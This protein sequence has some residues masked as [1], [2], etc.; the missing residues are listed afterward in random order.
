MNPDDDRPTLEKLISRMLADEPVVASAQ[1]TAELTGLTAEEA[2]HLNIIERVF[3]G[4]E[5]LRN[6]RTATAPAPHLPGERVGAFALVRPL[7]AGG[8][9]EVWLAERADGQVEQRVAMKFLRVSQTRFAEWFLREQ[10]LLARLEHPGIARF[11]DAGHA[12]DGAPYLAME[13]VDGEPVDAWC[14]ARALG[15]DARL[16]LFLRACES[17]DHAHRHLV[18]HRDVK[19]ANLLV[20]ADG[21]PKLLDFGIGKALGAVSPDTLTLQPALT[22][23]YAAPE[24]FR[25]EPVSTATD[26]FSLGLLL[27]R[28]LAGELPAA[29]ANA[30]VASLALGDATLESLSATARA[31]GAAPVAA[32][33]LTGD[34]DA[35]A[36]KATQTDPRERYGTVAAL[37]DDIERWRRRVPVA[38]RKATRGYRLRRFVA[39]HRAGVAAAAFAIVALAAG[40][41]VALW[42]ADI[43]RREAQRADA[44][45]AR[46]QRTADFVTGILRE[47]DPLERGRGEAR[48]ARDLVDEGVLRARSD[49]ADQ[50]DVRTAMLTVL[51]EA[52]YNLGD[53]AAARTLLDDA[54]SAVA[55]DTLD[56]ARIDGILARIAMKQGRSAAAI[57]LLDNA[58]ARLAAGSLDDRIAAARLETWRGDQLLRQ[59]KG[60]AGVAAM[61]AARASLASLV[62]PDSVAMLDVDTAFALR[63][64][65]MRQDAEAAPFLREL[66]ARIERV[67]GGDSARLIDPLGALA[68]LEKRAGNYDTAQT[69]YA[70][71]IAIA[72]QRLG[73][74][75]ETLA[76]LYSRSA[77]AY[78]DAGDPQRALERLALAEQALPPDANTERAQILAT[79][80]ATLLDVDRNA[81]AEQALRTALELRRAS[82]GDG[83]G[84]T[85]YS[86]SEWGRALRALGR[87]DEA[88]KVQREALERLERIMGSE[89][90]QLTFALRNLS[91][92][93]IAAGEFTQAADA[94]RRAATLA[95]K[96]YP[97]THRVVLQYQVMLGEALVKTGDGKGALEAVAPVLAARDAAGVKDL[98]EAAERVRAAKA[99]R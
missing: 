82:A 81:E 27:Y 70:R 65:D 34:L 89:A 13:Y 40:F 10:N 99:V 79:R 68:T 86:Q 33:R 6:E 62:K 19:P 78:Q 24:Q 57:P 4:F 88:R 64:A 60:D 37:A 49:L 94:L 3:A 44:Q 39:R 52:L 80:G 91:E 77:N 14:D 29:R 38:A 71:A 74:R 92:T 21:L 12:A 7:G 56:A 98:V 8:M 58:I 96:K 76:T 17:L 50:P 53:T 66:A 97:P 5:A 67:A 69:L 54:R 93:C 1:E 25:G 26:V 32:D 28:L 90:Y 84:L 59:G 42:Q 43:A 45:A 55:N 31:N 83:D 95:G 87:I 20:T 51:G 9:G 11:I 36:R 35:I 18:V 2:A 30:T 46:A 85:W 73:A 75:H 23:A 16:A 47:Q 72:T 22:L 41:A 15:L 48:T 61:R 63:L